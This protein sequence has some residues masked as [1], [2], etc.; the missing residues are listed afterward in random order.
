MKTVLRRFATRFASGSCA[1]LLAITAST[2]IAVVA[3]PAAAQALTCTITPGGTSS[4]GT[5]SSNALSYDYNGNY[6][7]S[8]LPAGS[9]TYAWSTSGALPQPISCSGA[10]CNQALEANGHDVREKVTVVA[11]HTGTGASYTLSVRVSLFAVCG[12]LGGLYWC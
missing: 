4:T 8:G 12:A 5:C 3:T 7:V 11:T 10:I 2:A 6:I 1:A 9:Y